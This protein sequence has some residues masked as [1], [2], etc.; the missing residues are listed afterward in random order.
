MDGRA[1]EG[2][3]GEESGEEVGEEDLSKSLGVA[4]LGVEEGELET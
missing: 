3:T 2:E 4:V 1:V